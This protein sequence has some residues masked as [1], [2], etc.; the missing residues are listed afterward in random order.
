M[1]KIYDEYFLVKTG[2]KIR[3]KVMTAR[4]TLTVIII[5]IC[6]LAMG[7]TAYA[8]FTYTISSGITTIRA[9][10]VDYDV[11]IEEVKTKEVGTQPDS[12][13]ASSRG[14]EIYVPDKDGYYVLANP[15]PEG[16]RAT[17]SDKIFN[18][19]IKETRE[20]TASVG[21]AK[22]EILTDVNLDANGAYKNSQ[23][24]YTKPIGK[25]VEDG[26][27]KENHDYKISIKVPAGQTAKV[28][29]I[30]KWGTCV[31]GPLVQDEA[32]L[33]VDYKNSQYM[34]LAFN[35]VEHSFTNLVTHK[36]TYTSIYDEP[37][38]GWL[39]ELHD[40]YGAKFSLYTYTS[41]LETYVTALSA[42]PINANVAEGEAVNIF[43]KYRVEFEEASDWLKIGLSAVDKEHD[44]SDVSIAQITSKELTD[45]KLASDV[46]FAYGKDSWK[47]FADAVNAMTGTFDSIDRMPRLRN[48]AGSKDT[49]LGM[50]S[51]EYG[52]LGFLTSGVEGKSYYL[53]E[54][55]CEFLKTHDYYVD[56]IEED[57][58]APIKLVF[59]ASDVQVKAIKARN[60]AKQLSLEELTLRYGYDEVATANAEQNAEAS[61]NV[62]KDTL[63]AGVIFANESDFYDANGF[64]E[65]NGV[66][67][68]WKTWYE[69]AC[70]FANE[71]FIDLNYSQNRTFEVVEL[72]QPENKATQ[73]ENG[74]TQPENGEEQPGNNS[75]QTGNAATQSENT[76]TQSDNVTGQSGNT[77]TQ[78]DNTTSQSNNLTTQTGNDAPVDQDKKDDSEENTES[79]DSTGNIG[80]E[81]SADDDSEKTE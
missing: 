35:E 60:D 71:H 41:V 36:D 74:E 30:E 50:Q 13:G 19:S 78:P 81:N 9:A 76:S 40:T 62:Y 21:Y 8:F 14:Q 24:Y 31:V 29:V 28:K 68:N 69:E 70:R 52:A 37:F 80:D 12:A 57:G 16:Q 47:A 53:E 20:S 79:S 23:T 44:F 3:D 64:I 33:T 2:E 6:L 56:V 72:P 39:K 25:Y 5:S 27:E 63:Y 75:E 61:E 67:A 32:N 45:G 59:V 38:F 4:V 66:A 26:T 43:A 54:N 22:I 11:A 1:K 55:A 65:Q 46:A 77:T 42:E 7:T 73:P 18:I 17:V 15:I 49:L 51:A 10:R 58:K 34:H 48:F